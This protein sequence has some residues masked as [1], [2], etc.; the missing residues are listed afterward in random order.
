[1]SHVQHMDPAYSPASTASVLLDMVRRRAPILMRSGGGSLASE[2]MNAGRALDP[3]L[4]T[5][6]NAL[7]KEGKTLHEI[8]EMLGVSYSTICKHTRA[9]RSHP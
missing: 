2:D 8:A 6:A 4:K 7:V 1:M 5:R 9:S 3:H